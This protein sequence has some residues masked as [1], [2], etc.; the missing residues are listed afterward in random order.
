M[1]KPVITLPDLIAN[2][3]GCEANIRASIEHH[4]A[5]FH[6]ATG[7]KVDGVTLDVAWSDSL[8]GLVVHSAAINLNLDDH[9]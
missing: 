4:L 9:A 8:N 7:V 1:T 6:D 2:K 3:R 5:A